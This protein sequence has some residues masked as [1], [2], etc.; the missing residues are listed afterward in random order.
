MSLADSAYHQI[1]IIE[2]CLIRQ[3]KYS[4]QELSELQETEVNI[5]YVPELQSVVCSSGFQVPAVGMIE[6]LILHCYILQ[7]SHCIE[8]K[9]RRC[10]LKLT[11]HELCDK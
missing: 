10:L 2:D 11:Q 7:N 4:K 3:L 8:H 5:T 6:W 9:S 1:I